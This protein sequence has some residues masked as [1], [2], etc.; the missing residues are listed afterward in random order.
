MV[1][2]LHVITQARPRTRTCAADQQT[3]HHPSPPA[4]TLAAIGIEPTNPRAQ[5]RFGSFPS[6]I[7][8]ARAAQ[9]VPG[10]IEMKHEIIKLTYDWKI[11]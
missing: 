4:T 6:T 8:F 7:P 9:G 10:L 2:T 1:T 3:R 5:K 11:S